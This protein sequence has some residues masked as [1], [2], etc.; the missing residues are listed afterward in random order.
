MKQKRDRILEKIKAS[1]LKNHR[2]ESE[3]LLLAVSKKQPIEK[4]KKMFELGQVN[5]AENYVQEFLEKKET[6]NNEKIKWHMIGPL[7]TNKVSKI[8]GE[9]DLIHS[10]DNLKLAKSI[11]E[12]S[13]EKNVVQKI[14]VQINVASESSKS[15]IDQKNARELIS[16]ILKLP[17]IKVVGLMTMPPLAE[18]P[19]ESRIHFEKLRK[20]RDDFRDLGLTEL[21][22][23]TTQDF[24]VAIE[25]GAT[26][27]RIGEALFG[28]RD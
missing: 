3:I 25:E 17:H 19:E 12:K 7:Q 2:N 13:K 14:L 1:C 15:G 8:V 16:E 10:V 20:I 4:I 11:S 18:K 22:M 23:G 21:S 24:E 6:L 26:I 27:I 5:F 28:P 9:V